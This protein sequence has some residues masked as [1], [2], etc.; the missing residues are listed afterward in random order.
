MFKQGAGVFTGESDD[1]DS[2]AKVVAV[3]KPSKL[4][5]IRPIIKTI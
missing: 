1:A 2:K 4:Q 5:K 3:W